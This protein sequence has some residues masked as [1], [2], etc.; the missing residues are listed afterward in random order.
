MAVPQANSSKLL[1]E[2]M[3]DGTFDDLRQR[4]VTQLKDH[5]RALAK[6]PPALQTHA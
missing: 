6:P 4:L 2:M 1:E 5:V 3:D